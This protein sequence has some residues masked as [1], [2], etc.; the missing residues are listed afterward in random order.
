M[1]ELAYQL[2]LSDTLD[3]GNV[4][5]EDI[6][7]EQDTTNEEDI[8]DRDSDIHV[9]LCYSCSKSLPIELEDCLQRWGSLLTSSNVSLRRLRRIC[10][11]LRTKLTKSQ[12]RLSD[13]S[14]LISQLEEAVK[15]LGA[16][17]EATTD[18]AE[19]KSRDLNEI[20]FK[21]NENYKLV[22]ELSSENLRLANENDVAEQLLVEV[23]HDQALLKDE[24]IKAHKVVTDMSMMGNYQQ[25]NWQPQQQRP[26]SPETSASSFDFFPHPSSQTVMTPARGGQRSHS[27][28]GPMQPPSN[29]GRG[30]PRNNRNNNK[31]RGASLDYASEAAHHDTST[32]RKPRSLSNR[33]QSTAALAGPNNACEVSSPDLGV[34][35]GSDPF[36]S[37]ERSNSV[38]MASSGTTMLRSYR[39]QNSSP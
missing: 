26:S 4:T 2:N 19:R 14:H 25:D 1:D 15:H 12:G 22:A 16:K 18:E 28:R 21:L 9:D 36:S 7:T 35:V 37:L 23:N 13:K 38:S 29:G 33:P 20:H 8:L 27:R 32:P 6:S 5:C 34:D 30:R 24:L 39:L 3:S 31:W 11:R 10:S 17:V